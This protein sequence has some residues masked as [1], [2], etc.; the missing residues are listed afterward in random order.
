MDYRNTRQSKKINFILWYPDKHSQQQQI[1]IVFSIRCVQAHSEF[2]VLYIFCLRRLFQFFS[3]VF[4]VE[5]AN[6][7][8]SDIATEHILFQNIPA[9]LTGGQL[10][11]VSYLLFISVF[12]VD[13]T[14]WVRLTNSFLKNKFGSRIIFYNHVHNI[15]R[16]FDGS[17]IF[18]LIR[19]ETKHGYQ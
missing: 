1:D 4:L 5:I 11:F 3:V 15:L 2:S 7:C 14:L 8:V 13:L 17:G 19:S 12:E 16:L 18:L 9:L 10:N 6:S